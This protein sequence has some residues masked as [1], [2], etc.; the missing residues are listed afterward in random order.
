MTKNSKESSES[1]EGEGKCK[2]A[3][4]IQLLVDD[5]ASND[6]IEFFESHTEECLS[7]LEEYQ[8]D[9]EFKSIIREKVLKLNIP[10]D[11][12]PSIKEKLAQYV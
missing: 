11:L 7:C 8:F 12:I 5:E 4:I 6:Q 10:N 9:A 2:C 1:K 3:E